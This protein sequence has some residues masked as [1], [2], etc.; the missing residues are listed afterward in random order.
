M[1]QCPVV[2]LYQFRESRTSR[3]S[4]QKIRILPLC[5]YFRY[6]R[7]SFIFPIRTFPVIKEKEKK[8]IIFLYTDVVV[9]LPPVQQ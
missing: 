2:A 7:F 3:S 6:L 8:Q 5:E 4:S 1:V 9:F